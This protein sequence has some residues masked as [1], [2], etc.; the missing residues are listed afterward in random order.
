MK[1]R[2]DFV[3]NSS[4]SSFICDVCGGVESGWDLC[5]SDVDMYECENG[6]VFHDFHMKTAYP[7]ELT[8][9]QILDILESRLVSAENSVEFNPDSSWAIERFENLKKD[10]E[11][12]KDKKEDEDLPLIIDSLT[13]DHELDSNYDLS[14]KWCP[15]C[16]ME[17]LS[18]SDIVGFLY[19]K[20]NSTKEN[21]MSE[22]REKFSNYDEL[23]SFIRG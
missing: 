4:S 18:N 14:S 9:E 22:M 5:L 23:K 2:L 17:S 10:I 16:Q 6:H 7:S 19:K 1:V 8:Y 11:E 15:I 12:L 20:L 3:T 21:I 13:S